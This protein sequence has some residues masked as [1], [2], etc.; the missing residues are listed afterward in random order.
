MRG[1]LLISGCAEWAPTLANVPVHVHIARPDPFDD[2]AFI[3]QWSDASPGA[4]L[5]IHRY[6]GAGHYFLDRQPPDYD[7]VA[8]ALCLDRCQLFLHSL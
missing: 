2:E 8:A 6:D 3:A 7:A 4:V 5:E 1:A